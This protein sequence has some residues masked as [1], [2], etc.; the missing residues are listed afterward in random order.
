MKND[1][2]ETNQKGSSKSKIVATGKIEQNNGKAKLYNK[3][4]YQLTKGKS[5]LNH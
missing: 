2:I 5:Q 4:H 3:V 1:S